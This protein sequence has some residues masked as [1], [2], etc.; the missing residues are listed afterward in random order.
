M[1]RL[2]PHPPIRGV[3]AFRG[4]IPCSE[5]AQAAGE[6]GVRRVR[7]AASGTR[8]SAQKRA[9]AVRF[10]RRKGEHGSAIL[11]SF[12]CMILIGMIL[13]GV[14]QLFQL[15][16]ADMIAEYAAFRGARSHVVGFKDFYAFREALIKSAPASGAMIAPDPDSYPG[17]YSNQAE[18]EKTLLRGFMQG[19]RNV[20]YAYWRGGQRFHLSYHCP[21]YGRPMHYA[22][23]YCTY[24]QNDIRSPYVMM[25]E[26]GGPSSGS[27]FRFDFRNYPLEIPLHDWLTGTD[28]ITI[29]SK[30][31]L[32]RR[33]AFLE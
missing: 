25:E 5:A 13:F 8:F 6:R 20:E 30:A 11:E 21:D 14:L 16:L 23:P 10:A 32:Q 27:S 1:R 4:G 28:S 29:S 9:A 15:A 19:D 22:C 17:Y 24:S 33:P 2:S 18:T 7:E 12:L 26:N 3:P 31:E